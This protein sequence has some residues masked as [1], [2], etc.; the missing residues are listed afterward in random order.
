MTTP[1]QERDLREV[2]RLK[3]LPIGEGFDIRHLDE[4]ERFL[5]LTIDEQQIYMSTVSDD[6]AELFIALLTARALYKDPVDRHPGSITQDKVNAY[7]DRYQWEI[8]AAD[9]DG[10]HLKGD[11]RHDG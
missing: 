2:L 11:R 1:D 7:P 9:V 8:E 10:A 4:Y 5:G 3:Y 6:A